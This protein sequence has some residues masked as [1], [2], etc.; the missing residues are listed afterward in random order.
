MM[1][2]AY[3][4]IIIISLF[5][6]FLNVRSQCLTLNVP[7]ENRVNDADLIIEGSVI[8]K[9][10][11]WNEDK[12][13]IYTSNMVDVYKIFKGKLLNNQIEVVTEGGIV[14]D[15]WVRI[16]PALEVTIGET[17]IFLLNTNDDKKANSNKKGIAS[18]RA[19][20]MELG[21]IKYDL[22]DSFKAIGVH[23]S[24]QNIEGEL[25]GKI[26]SYTKAAIQ[27][28]NTFSVKSIKKEVLASR[29]QNKKAPT[30]TSFSPST[31]AAGDKRVLTIKG[32]GFGNSRGSNFVSF[33]N[34][35]DGGATWVDVY[36]AG[37]SNMNDYYPKWTDTEI[38]VYVPQRDGSKKF[39]AGT[40]KVSVVIGGNRAISSQTLI[41]KWARYEALTNVGLFSATLSN[42]D[43]TGG[44]TWRMNTSFAANSAAAAAFQRALD[45]WSCASQVNWK[46]G[47]NTTIN[48]K[49]IDGVSVM[50]FANSQE[51]LPNGVLASTA[52]T[53][54]QQCGT[55]SNR[56]WYV[57]E[58]DMT[59]NTSIIIGSSTY[60]WQYGPS[61]ANS[62]Q[63]DFETTIVH[64]LGHAHQL[65]HII[66][67]YKIMHWTISNGENTRSV[68]PEM[69]EGANS[70]T[71]ESFAT[72]ICTNSGFNFGAMVPYTPSS[73]S[74]TGI[75]ENNTITTTE[76]LS[77][78]PNPTSN[79][80][81]IDM[82][83]FGKEE[84]ITRIL[85][86]NMLGEDIS[87]QLNIQTNNNKNY[88]LDVGGQPEGVYFVKVV[89]NNQNVITT[90]VLVK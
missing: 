76:A 80:L 51:T 11:Y 63:W 4:T 85:V 19:N 47:S 50:H 39:F 23:D 81:F 65:G 88:K 35:N 22:K 38:Q 42:V 6:S 41:I 7:L 36:D 26:I 58:M 21:F 1:Q 74:P 43:G 60:N 12:S 46:I 53:M 8:S 48:K 62:S 45:T 57:Y 18:F 31:I 56:R 9:T 90:K 83:L 77:I 71:T 3:S 49:A 67:Q 17:G 61:P 16:N 72:P 28:V 59:M 54:R 44:I 33:Y 2:K 55:S 70:I 14:D 25:Y 84:I 82:H 10:S 32:S 34:S 66:D 87:D 68:H 27:N 86:Y 64:E 40:G 30:I 69:A 89:L 78:Y 73:C 79:E 52:T 24:Y 5:F 37:V 13:K 75:T 15:Y 29:V 20:R